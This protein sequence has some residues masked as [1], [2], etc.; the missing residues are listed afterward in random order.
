MI[1]VE[2]EPKELWSG[3]AIECCTFCGKYTRYWHIFTNNPVCKDCSEVREVSELV[4]HKKVK[5]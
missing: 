2:L 3:S 1:P 4:N 5:Q